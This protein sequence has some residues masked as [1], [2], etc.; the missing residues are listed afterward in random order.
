[1]HGWL[2]CGFQDQGAGC[3]TGRRAGERADVWAAPG[4]GGIGG[5]QASHSHTVIPPRRSLHSPSPFTCD[6]APRSISHPRCRRCPV[7]VSLSLLPVSDRPGR[8]WTA[9][10]VWSSPPSEETGMKAGTRGWADQSGQTLR[11]SSRE[12]GREAGLMADVVVGL[13]HRRESPCACASLLWC[14]GCQDWSSAAH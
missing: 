5:A 4:K 8:R 14:E 3:L 6:H 11:C 7:T 2:G 9:C 12:C 10:V 13:L 1:M